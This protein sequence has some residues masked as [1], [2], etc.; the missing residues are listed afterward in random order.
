MSSISRCTKFSMCNPLPSLRTISATL[1]MLAV[2][3]V[4]GCSKTSSGATDPGAE[5]AN[6]NISDQDLSTD[7]S[8]YGSGNIP[9]PEEGGAL[10]DVMFD[11][12]SSAVKAEYHAQLQTGAKMLSGDPS[13]R[14]EVEGHCDK[15]GTNEYNLALGQERAKAVASLM[16]SFGVPETQISTVS[17]GEEIPLDPSD[18]EAAYIKNRRAHFALYRSKTPPSAAGGSNSQQY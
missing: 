11:Y 12:D 16:M 18:T 15:R 7:A 17:Y 10:P 6:A 2:I 14:A 9:L 3:P 4:Y 1:L 8:R 13:L 5:G